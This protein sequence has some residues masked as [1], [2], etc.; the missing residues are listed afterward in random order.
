MV[1]PARRSAWRLA[2]ALRG[3]LVAGVLLPPGG[4]DSLPDGERRVLDK[5]I[6]LAEDLGARLRLIEAA[7]AAPAIAGAVRDEHA[8]LVVMRHIRKAG[9]RRMFD[10]SLI[11]ELL[12]LLDN[13][14]LHIVEA[15][16][17]KAADNA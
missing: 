13:V 12:D 4:R 15:N 7:N 17:G 6:L 11:D 3:E 2:S 10:A 16:P 9:W 14:D 5:N 8:T 1:R